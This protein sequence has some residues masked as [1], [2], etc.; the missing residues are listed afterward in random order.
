MIDF[1]LLGSNRSSNQSN[2][3]EKQQASGNK[4][5][6]F[7]YSSIGVGSGG[8]GGALAPPACQNALILRQNFGQFLIFRAV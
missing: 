3:V 2:T 7:I 6:S 5:Q 4:I 8:S 1:L